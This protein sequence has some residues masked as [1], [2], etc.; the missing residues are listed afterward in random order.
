M[1]AETPTPSHPLTC[2]VAC[3]DNLT[4]SAQ[5]RGPRL[6]F[7]CL[8][9][10]FTMCYTGLAIPSRLPAQ[11]PVA[12]ESPSHWVS[13]LIELVMAGGYAH[14]QTRGGDQGIKTREL[15]GQSAVGRAG[16]Q[17]HPAGAA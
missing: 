12:P 6:Q 5:G 15:S 4:V 3:P 10:L 13:L 16:D 2:T 1:S 14:P 9:Y 11:G 8:C 17:A 7:L